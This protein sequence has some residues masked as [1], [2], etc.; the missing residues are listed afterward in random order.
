MKPSLT[1]SQVIAACFVGV[2]LGVSYMAI[3]CALV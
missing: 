3:V 2:F 1:L